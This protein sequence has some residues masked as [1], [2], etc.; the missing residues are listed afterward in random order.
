[1]SNKQNLLFHNENYRQ[2]NLMNY[3]DETYYEKSLRNFILGHIQRRFTW[4]MSRNRV[5]WRKVD[6]IAC[7]SS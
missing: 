5:L 7:L 6:E 3:A 1:M 2:P 4:M